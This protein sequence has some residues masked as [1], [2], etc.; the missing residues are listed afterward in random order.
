MNIKQ[1]LV[2]LAFWLKTFPRWSTDTHST[3]GSAGSGR[4]SCLIC[5]F[6]ETEEVR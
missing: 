5:D 1:Y 3:A 6:V 2:H 4:Y